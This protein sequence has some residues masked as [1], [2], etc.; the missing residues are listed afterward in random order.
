MRLPPKPPRARPQV[1]VGS[2]WTHGLPRRMR[3]SSPLDSPISPARVGHFEREP[4]LY[5]PPPDDSPR[6]SSPTSAARRTP[7]QPAA[8]PPKSSTVPTLIFPVAGAADVHRRLRPAARRR[9]ASGQRPDGGE[10]DPGRRRRGRQGQVLDDVRER[11][12]HALSLRRERN[13]VRVH[14]SEQRPDDAQRQPRQVRARRVVCA[15]PEG[16]REGV[17]R[18]DDRLR[19][20]LGRCERDRVAP[21]LRGASGRRR[22]GLAVSL[23]AERAEAPV[24]REDRHAVH[25]RARPERSSARPTRRSRSRLRRCRLSR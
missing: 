8:A 2:A 6:S 23:P 13:D 24:L 10:E 5:E 11:R 17:G 21:A 14:P 4:E 20:R 22:G 12:L 9:H 16:R 3:D 19:R 7:G 18:P 1:R 25:A 15:R